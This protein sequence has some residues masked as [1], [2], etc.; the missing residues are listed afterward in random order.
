MYMNYFEDHFSYITD[1]EHYAKTFS[2]TQCRRLFT[3][4]R[5]LTKHIP[6]CKEHVTYNFPG[7]VFALSVSIFDKLDKLGIEI[8]QHE[9]YYP[10][11]ITYDIETNLD[12][13]CASESA[14]PKLSYL[15]Q[16]KLLSVSVCSNVEGY[17]TPHC[18]ISEGDPASLVDEFITY[19]HEISQAAFASITNSFSISGAIS[20]LAELITNEETIATN[21]SDLH[22]ND[23][24]FLRNVL[25][26][27]LGGLLN[28]CRQIPVI[29]FNSGKY[30]I[31]VMKGLMYQSLEKLHQN[32]DE[33]AHD[34]YPAVSQVIKRNGDYMSISSKWLKFL[35]IKNYLAPGFSYKQFL[36]AYKCQEEKGF[37]PYD[38]MDGLEKL[39]T[40]SLPSH[41]NFYNKLKGT[42][43]S[44]VEYQ[45]CQQVWQDHN[46]TSFCHFLEWYNNKDVV[47]F[48]EALD[49]M[50][51]FYKEKKVDMFK[52]GISVPGLTLR[53]LFKDIR[54]D[55]FCLFPESHK[56]LYFLF[57]NN[58]VGGPSIIFHRYQEK[59]RSRI[60]NGKKCEQVLGFDANALYLWAIMQDMPTGV[61]LRRRE[62]T[63]F[64]REF[65]HYLQKTA[66]SWL[67]WEGQT[68]GYDQGVVAMI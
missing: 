47:P 5:N 14:A 40:T 36:E 23:S 57:K 48:L 17:E 13:S 3:R 9:R 44:S 16:H 38:W 2:C 66:A 18:F 60:R 54:K 58:I 51:H 56:D 52:Q 4:N 64:R 10:Y 42:N 62:E 35:D 12:H 39:S 25:K 33:S 55:F 30:D 63:G 11:R 32:E 59:G 8:P 45:Y 24:N 65:T 37:F 19:C 21:N 26:P 67:E 41:D 22:E 20:T 68:R 53:Y 27:T 31:N 15:G 29:G 28:Y 6:H 34:G 50:F 61:V 43:I 1:I 7:G 49:K 46:M